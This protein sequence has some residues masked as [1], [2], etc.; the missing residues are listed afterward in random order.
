MFGASISKATM[1]P[2]PT[3]RLEAEEREDADLLAQEAAGTLGKAGAAAKAARAEKMAEKMAGA[4]TGGAKAAGA[5]RSVDRHLSSR[6]AAD[7][8]SSTVHMG[9]R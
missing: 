9:T 4:K 8:Q 1:R 7:L 5:A 2:N 6:H 3:A